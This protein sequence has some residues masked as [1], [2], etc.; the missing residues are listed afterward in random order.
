MEPS[1]TSPRR[2]G[3]P[4]TRG[5][6]AAAIAVALA[7]ALAA[8]W[9]VAA[10]VWDLVGTPQAVRGVLLVVCAALA[11]LGGYG[12][13]RGRI[14]S[15]RL[16]RL[17]LVAWVVAAG[18]VALMTLGAWILLGTPAWDP[19]DTLTPRALD[20]VATR[21]FG[22]VA[23]LGGVALLIISYRRQRAT[24]AENRREET[25]LFNERFTTAYANLGSE[26][27][28]V[29]LGAVHALA[30]LADDAPT[31]ALVQMVIDVL[32]AYLR[33]P[34][35]PEPEPL[36]DGADQA[37]RAEHRRER[38]EFFAFREV[39]HTVIRLISNHLGK[40]NPTRW[41]GRNYDFTDAVFDGGSFTGA[42]FTGSTVS[43]DNAEFT[44]G[45]VDFSAATFP[46]VDF[47]DAGFSGR[48]VSFRSAAF[49]GGRGGPASARASAM[50]RTSGGTAPG[51]GVV[52]FRQ[53]AFA[54]SVVRFDNATFAGEHVDFGYTLFDGS[55]V[56]FADAAFASGTAVNFGKAVFRS[57][58]VRFNDAVGPRPEGLLEAREGARPGVV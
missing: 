49:P 48:S 15:M 55:A 34:Y 30:N 41:R 33:M 32:C 27:A 1:D 26:H 18:A 10:S 29:R 2:S 47:R 44:S 11:A 19:P 14:A 50:A 23:G 21:A 7:G 9:P 37:A 42:V 53:C 40:D 39:R 54:G 4:G 56:S 38:L 45:A 24:E 25:R 8:L 13:R 52:S 51:R 5:I 6:W 36:P 3:G 16:A 58:R 20:A 12:L 17:I 28:A 57:G 35:T 22:I 46:T 43:F 31:D